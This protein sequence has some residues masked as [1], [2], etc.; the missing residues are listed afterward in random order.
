MK[1]KLSTAFLLSVITLASAQTQ[2]TSQPAQA[3]L[4]TLRKD[5][6][7]ILASKQDFTALRERIKT[8]P[9][10][11][12]WHTLLKTQ[13]EKLLTTPPVKHEILDGKR[14]LSISREALK[15]VQL[16]AL[17]WQL[18]QDSRYADRLWKELE[19]VAN[20]P[21]WN[22]K[23]FLDT[24]EM[25]FA[26]ALAYD[27]LYHHWNPDQRAT[28]C[29]ALLKHGLNPAN[30]AIKNNKAW[31]TTS[32]HNWNQVCNGGIGIGA[33]ALAEDEPQ[34]AEDLLK[35][36]IKN[37]PLAM[38][39]Y[40]PDGAWAEGPGYWAYATQYNAAILAALDSA[41]GTDHNLSKIPGF[42][43]AGDMPIHCNTPTGKIFN[44]ADA[45]NNPI[46][47]STLFWLAQKYNAPRFAHHRL[48][49]LEGKIPG[50]Y[51]PEPLD[52]L[53]YNPELANKP[54]ENPPLAK[55]FR[56]TEIVTVRSVWNDPNATFLAFKAGSNKVNHSHLDLGSFILESQG[57]RFFIDPGSEDYN[58]P[59][60]F[61][62]D[63]W[64][65]YRLR[66]EGHNTLVINPTEKPDQDPIANSKIANFTPAKNPIDSTTFAA[67]LT[68][69]YANHDAKKITRAFSFT[70]NTITLTDT[71][72]LNN[73]GKI[74]WF[75]HTMADVE[76]SNKARTA[77]LTQ[78]NAKIQV[79]IAKPD[80]AQFTLMDAKPLPT[81]PN[82]SGQ[83]PNDGS[84]RTNS[85]N[86]NFTKVG[87]LPQ[88]SNPNPKAAIRKLSILLRDTTATTIEVRIAKQ[89]P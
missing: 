81:S 70:P 71:I 17:L 48:A 58:L 82:P 34:L 50:T 63:R 61:G 24:A 12:N 9:R 68:P 11:K 67:D 60:Y 4:S 73:P 37:L 75:A 22:P 66:A 45:G 33:L 78:G 26:V 44:F 2:P 80:G 76:I 25:S 87:T 7:R 40:A 88:W 13:A 46:A 27:W 51:N 32:H 59:N 10:S 85:P 41:L 55:Y 35:T 62:P 14:L 65:Y 28:L 16:L 79:T 19:A 23:H 29:A 20:F 42:S 57:Q 18:D 39:N 53:W 86:T 36:V 84:T 15:R 47:S 74:W 69:A 72:E 3:F 89:N 64:N 21:D 49:Q 31:W 6:P 52:L 38:K 1:L 5:H 83:N 54:E 43:L 30:E 77:T 56:G 8:D